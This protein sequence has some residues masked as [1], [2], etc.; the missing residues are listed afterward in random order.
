MREFNINTRKLEIGNIGNKLFDVI[1]VGGGITGA[2]TAN[3]LSTTGLKVLLLEKGDFA[4]GTSSAS[5]KLIHGGLRY[6]QQGRIFLTKDLIREREYLLRNTSIV[7][8]IGFRI[9]IDGYSPSGLSIKFGLFLY[10]MLSGKPR[11]PRF[12]VNN[13]ELVPEVK[14]YYSFYDAMTDDSTLVIHN[15]ASATMRGVVCLNYCRVTGI[16]EDD[17]VRVEF[18]DVTTNRKAYVSGKLIINCAGPWADNV[19]LLAGKA[20]NGAKLSG[21][22]HIVVDKSLYEGEDAIAFFSHLDGRQM[23]IIPREK[24]NIIGT[25]DIL[26]TSPDNNVPTGEE[27]E[28]LIKSAQRLIPQLKQSSVLASFYG[29][30]PLLGHGKDPG[31]VTRNFRILENGK[32]LSVYGVKL[33]DF[34]KASRKVAQ[35][36]SKKLGAPALA[37]EIPTIDYTRPENLT[38]EYILNFECP[39]TVEDI[40][41]R[42]IPVEIYDPLGKEKLVHECEEFVKEGKLVKSIMT[43]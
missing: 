14:G 25:T 6:L 24:V 12:T 18:L 39:L 38:V 22:T 2:G 16:Q 15:I 34:R 26:T 23:F 13:G 11:I 32:M 19:Q 21:G 10:S 28:Y 41:R 42:R 8:K 4:S 5:S 43:V 35:R 36:I 7:K 9:L 37:K 3:A 30:R 33:T 27:I 31:K 1:I 17:A 40:I 20:S 29:T